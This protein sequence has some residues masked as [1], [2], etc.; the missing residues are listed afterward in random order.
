MR[1]LASCY[2]LAVAAMLLNSTSAAHPA[3]WCAL[4]QTG[5]TNCGFTT[6]S[7]CQATI[8]GIGGMC[9]QSPY[10]D[11][12]PAKR[13]KAL[14]KQKSETAVGRPVRPA[15]TTAPAPAAATTTAPATI[16][17]QPKPGEFAAARKLILDGQYQA[18]ITAMRALGSDNN[19][20]VAAYIGLALRKLGRIDEAK[21]WYERALI[22]TTS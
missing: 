20:D 8:S 9:N 4:Y 11:A 1:S 21:S 19:S 12:Q 14:S 18:G 6:F 16:A 17:A 5:G 7:Q 2:G 13:E 22:R 3:Q 15:V 10:Q